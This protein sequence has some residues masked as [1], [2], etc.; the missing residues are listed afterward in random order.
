MRLGSWLA[1][2]EGIQNEA[3]DDLKEVQ[4]EDNYLH[5]KPETMDLKIKMVKIKE[6]GNMV[7][8]P[9]VLIWQAS[10]NNQNF[11]SEFNQRMEK[12][13]CDRAKIEVWN[14]IHK[15]SISNLQCGRYQGYQRVRGQLSCPM[16]S[17]GKNG[18]K[19]RNQTVAWRENG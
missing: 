4:L 19:R 2:R 18:S 8:R 9:Y 6:K 3:L 10:S 16:S 17:H 13:N 12:L 15:S 5:Q 11:T 14:N 7:L 1:Q